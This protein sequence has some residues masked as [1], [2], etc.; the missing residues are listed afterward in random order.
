MIKA[1]PRLVLTEL[2]SADGPYRNLHVICDHL[3]AACSAFVDD[4]KCSADAHIVHV[5]PRATEVSCTQVTAD[6][7]FA[8]YTHLCSQVTAGDTQVTRR[9]SCA[10]NAQLHLQH[11]HQI[12]ECSTVL[13][14]LVNLGV[15]IRALIA[16]FLFSQDT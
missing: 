2:A 8:T 13:L 3:R 1:V 5:R 10:P 16:R 9:F 12:L 11:P 4:R 15:S 6:V 7:C 14:L